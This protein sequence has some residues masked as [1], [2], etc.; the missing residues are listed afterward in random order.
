MPTRMTRPGAALLVAVV[1]VAIASAMLVAREQET[2]APTFNLLVPTESG[3]HEE[4][5]PGEDRSSLNIMPTR[6][7]IKPRETSASLMLRNDSSQSVRFQ[8]TAFAWSNDAN[9][10]I[11]LKPTT[12]LVFFPTLLTIEPG[13]S[14]RVRVAASQ[15]A[16]ER[17]LA[18][19]LM[20]EQLPSRAEAPSGGGVQMLMRASVPVFVQAQP[21]VARAVI[22]GTRIAKG[23]AVFD[24]RNVGTTHVMI[25]QAEVRGTT[26]FAQRLPG[27]YL[28]SGETRTYRVALPEEVCRAQE[29][30]TIA[31]SFDG[32]PRQTMTAEQ[33][34]M[35]GACGA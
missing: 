2:S 19:R 21:M 25:V 26:S 18:Y 22:E 33:D 24:V 13:E 9:G 8:V 23:E 17:E 20:I 6:V 34:I 32:N 3:R 1:A 10:Q 14:R 28:L 30:L 31:V 15:R 12:D 35:P 16:V 27:W 29:K 4:R 11:V 5:G 7:V